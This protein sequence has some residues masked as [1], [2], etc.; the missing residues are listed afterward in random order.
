MEDN[1]KNKQKKQTEAK[2]NR[3]WV[4]KKLVDIV[5][6]FGFRKLDGYAWDYYVDP[7][8]GEIYEPNY[9]RLKELKGH[10]NGNGYLKVSLKG[11]DGKFHSVY[12]HREMKKAFHANPENKEYVHHINHNRKDNRL[13]NLDWASPKEN[14]ADRRKKNDQNNSAHEGM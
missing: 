1:H 5:T 8:T 3:L 12:I 6:K 10:D 14:C 2:E 11:L 7:R 13:K 9:G 4:G